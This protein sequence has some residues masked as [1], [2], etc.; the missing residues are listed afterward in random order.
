MSQ[1]NFRNPRPTGVRCLGRNSPH[2]LIVL[3]NKKDHKS[4]A[5]IFDT[6]VSWLKVDAHK[7]EDYL[8]DVENLNELL[9]VL[10]NFS[11]TY[12]I[13]E[14]FYVLNSLKIIISISDRIGTF[15][16]NKKEIVQKIVKQLYELKNSGI[17]KREFDKPKKGEGTRGVYYSQSSAHLEDLK[18]PYNIQFGHNLIQVLRDLLEIIIMLIEKS[19]YS[20]RKFIEKNT[21]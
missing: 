16:A 7:I 9:K 15:I 11:S 14:Y 4:N 13:Q 10:L 8:W 18:N 17:I 3:L 21:N 1:H 19:K 2:L 20:P 12:G 6:L 5:K